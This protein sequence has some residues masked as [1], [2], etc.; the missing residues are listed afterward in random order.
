[1][2]KINVP[3][4]KDYQNSENRQ[5]LMR[6]LYLDTRI[7]SGTDY[8]SIKADIRQSLLKRWQILLTNTTRATQLRRLKTR[9]EMWPTS[10]RQTI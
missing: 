4:N 10:N 8:Q 7:E 3:C 6:T 1:M 9:I 2:I 5:N